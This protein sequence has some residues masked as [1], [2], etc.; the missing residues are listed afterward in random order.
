MNQRDTYQLWRERLAILMVVAFC[1][2]VSSADY[3]VHTAEL[4][5]VSTYQ[6]LGET[7]DAGSNEKDTTFIH[8]AVDAVV[9]FVMV[10]VEH[11]LHF[12][13]E[14]TTPQK[15]ATFFSTNFLALPNSFLEVLFEHIVSANAP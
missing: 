13:Y 4:E 8:T 10:A 5:G 15:P 12:I 9:P 2:L 6:V 14:L 11:V 1:A 7:D 3:L